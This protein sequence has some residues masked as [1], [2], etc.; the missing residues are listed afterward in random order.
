MESKTKTRKE[1]DIL[2]LFAITLL[3]S[4]IAEYLF[5]KSFDLN[6]VGVMFMLFCSVCAMYDLIKIKGE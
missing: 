5:K 1:N 6:N 2:I 4:I 3:I